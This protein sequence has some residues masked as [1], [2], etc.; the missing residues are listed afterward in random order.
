MFTGIVQHVGRITAFQPTPAGVRLTLDPCGWSHRP[1]RGDSIA[2]SGTCLT[3]V[4]VEAGAWSFDVIPQT[5]ARTTLGSMGSASGDAALQPGR[6]VNL[7]HAVLASTPMGGHIVQGHVDGVGRV[8]AITTTGEWRVRIEPPADAA[9]SIVAQGS[10]TVDGV[11]LT[12]AGA[13]ADGSWFEVA[14]IPETLARTTLAS[15]AVGDAVNI[16]VD[17]LAKLI[18]REVERRLA[19]G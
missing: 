12:V 15:L 1:A 10:I 6:S 13:A 2:V 17:H 18:A 19:R 5:L 3:V 16:E 4:Q 11:S 7:E 8:A 9:S 14:L